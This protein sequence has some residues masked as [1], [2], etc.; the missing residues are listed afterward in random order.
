MC[1][2]EEN[3]E[4]KISVVTM[5]YL[6]IS[7]RIIVSVTVV[8]SRERLSVSSHL[9]LSALLRKKDVWPTLF[10]NLQFN[11]EKLAARKQSAVRLFTVK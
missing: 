1:F 5:K 8:S 11:V 6:Q 3:S 2:F 9:R 4:K 7:R 10:S